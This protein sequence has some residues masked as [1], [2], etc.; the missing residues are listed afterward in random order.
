MMVNVRSELFRVRVDFRTD[1]R[2]ET[3]LDTAMIAGIEGTKLGFAVGY[4]HA[5]IPLPRY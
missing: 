1:F 4:S 3:E 5:A 2:E